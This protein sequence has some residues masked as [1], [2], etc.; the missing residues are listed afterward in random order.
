[1][2]SPVPDI[3]TLQIDPT[4]D[5]YIVLACDGIWNS[6]TSQEVVDFVSERIDKL[7]SNDK[8]PDPSTVH[9]KTICEEVISFNHVRF[10]LTS[11]I[12]PA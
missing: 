12:T 2:I 5:S 11:G 7:C 6:L 3:R 9:L 4:K 10:L 8:H 1:M